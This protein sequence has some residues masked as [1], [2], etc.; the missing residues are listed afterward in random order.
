LK[1]TTGK[2]KRRKSIFKAL[3]LLSVMFLDDVPLLK[4]F[5]ILPCMNFFP[6]RKCYFP[7]GQY[8]ETA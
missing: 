6:L 3:K 5:L 4:T 7:A 2:D 1:K 8:P